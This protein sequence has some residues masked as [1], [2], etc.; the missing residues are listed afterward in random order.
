MGK[1]WQQRSIM[2]SPMTVWWELVVVCCQARA[3]KNIT[4]VCIICPTL[5]TL[6]ELCEMAMVTRKKM[7]GSPS[8]G[9]LGIRRQRSKPSSYRFTW[10]KDIFLQCTSVAFFAFYPSNCCMMSNHFINKCFVYGRVTSKY[11][12]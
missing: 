5:T 4:Q 9:L 1:P 8:Y 7:T 2:A 3:T 12:K 11:H 10:I 6:M